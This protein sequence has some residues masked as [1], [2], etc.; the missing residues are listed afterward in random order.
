MRNVLND[1]YYDQY[2]SKGFIESGT[3]LPADMVDDIKNH[4]LAFDKGRND[5]P[6]FFVNNEHQ[7]YF[8]G[9]TLGVLFNAFP[10]T[11]RKVVSRFYDKAYSKAVYCQQANIEKVLTHLLQN[12]FQ[13]L[14]RTRYIVAGYDMYLRNSHQS[15]P[16][17][18][19]SDLPN[20][21]HFYETEND[22]SLYIPLVD[23]DDRN[24]GRLS[25]LP[26]EKLKLPGNVLLRLLH[27]HFSRNPRYLDDDGYIDPDRI[28][29][30]A[31]T[32]FAKS[33]PHQD[34]MT[35]YKGAIALAK[36]QYAN[37][38]L[39]T[40]ES[41]GRVLLFNNKN[42]HAAE[43]WRNEQYDREV[44]VIRMFPLYDAKIKLKRQLHGT[45][46]N[47]YLIDMKLGTVQRLDDRV[48]TAGIPAEEKLRA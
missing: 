30:E 22:L 12:G 31:I 2:Y 28:E 4:Y 32:A 10:K 48:D 33:K 42:F 6:K 20:F 38:Y 46:V 8:E 7:A 21:H 39:K 47:N 27:D 43:K 37:D 16:A 45:L 3:T 26:E 40:D 25:V 34:L 17:G 29:A 5:F 35:L 18:I 15:P 36:T 1:P 9:Q 23:L 24:G 19:H 41:K 11:A 44:Y 13:R 14:F